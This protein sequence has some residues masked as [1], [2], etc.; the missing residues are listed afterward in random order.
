MDAKPFVVRLLE[1]EETDSTNSLLERLSRAQE[2]AEGTVVSARYQTAGRGQAGRQW[3]SDAGCNVLISL[4]LRPVFLQPRHQ[5]FLNQALA[6]AIADT[7]RHFMPGHTVAVKW[8]NDVLLN[9]KKVAGLLLECQLE[10]NSF[11]QVISGIGLNVNQP[12]F[13]PSLPLATSFLLES[14][15]WNDPEQVRSHLLQEIGN[16][17]AQ[18]SHGAYERIGKE[19]MKNLYGL[20]QMLAFRSGDR[21]FRGKITGLSAE[22]KLII[23]TGAEHEVFGF[24]EVEFLQS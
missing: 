2:L 22:G 10:G 18:L 8:P 11:R 4:L 5:F 12:Q 19:Y 1:V 9:G 7:V 23:D 21:R 15:R 13:P 16:R 14:D 3:Y 6:L 17:Y 20:E 24:K